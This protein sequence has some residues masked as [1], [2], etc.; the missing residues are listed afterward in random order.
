M[1]DKIVIAVIEGTVREGRQS[2]MA[3]KFI[4]SVAEGMENVEVIFVDPRDFSFPHDGSNSDGNDP[5]ARDP[6]YTEITAKADAFFIVTPEYN[7]SFPGSLKRMF[8]SEY[9]NYAHK[10]VAIAGV[11][12]G[13][14]GGARAVEGLLPSFRTVGLY[15]T[16]FSTYFPR[17]QDSFDA[18]GKILPEKSEQYTKSVTHQLQELVWLARALKQAR[19]QLPR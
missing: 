19:N 18:D 6:K 15:V 7:H 12:N 8:D 4:A 2:I 1:D 17:I 3:A 9:A 10:A 16:Q 14:W 13:D 11:S 5:E